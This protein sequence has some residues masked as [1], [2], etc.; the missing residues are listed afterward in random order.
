MVHMRILEK[1]ISRWALPNEEILSWI[2]WDGSIDFDRI[3]IRSE[4]DIDF[5]RILNVDAS[6]FDQEKIT[7][8]EVIIH[9]SMLQMQGFVGFT[10]VYTLL[11]ESER[12]LGFEVDFM[13]DGK[14]LHIIS[15]STEL[16]R[17][18]LVIEKECDRIV[19]SDAGRME[20]VSPV[21]FKLSSKGRAIVRNLTP[22]IEFTNTENMT[23]G[24]EY[25]KEKIAHAPDTPFVFASEQTIPKFVFRGSG[26]VLFAMVFKYNDAIGNEY[27]SSPISIPVSLPQKGEVKIPIESQLEGQS[28]I[29][30][31]PIGS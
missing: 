16:I 26:D 4:A 31:T 25:V 7:E 15:L 28:P 24:I 20:P 8:G 2:K 9:R 3:V 5:K 12:H 10:C 30:L 1:H 19:I 14:S 29:I 27:V 23:I 22:F 11:P 21:M 18:I 17:P 6:V 13:K